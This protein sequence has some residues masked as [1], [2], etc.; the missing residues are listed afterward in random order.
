MSK[1]EKADQPEID[2]AIAR[3]ATPTHE[4]ITEEFYPLD[5]LRALQAEIEQRRAENEW[6][7]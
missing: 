5:V 1:F 2:A 6:E 7:S 4:Q 3:Q